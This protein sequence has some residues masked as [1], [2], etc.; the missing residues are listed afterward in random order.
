MS[1]THWPAGTFNWLAQFCS[2]ANRLALFAESQAIAD[3]ICTVAPHYQDRAL[4]DAT[5]LFNQNRYQEA[6]EKLAESLRGDPN[7]TF[8]QYVLYVCLR[9]AGNPEW[10]HYAESVASAPDHDLCSVAR[11]DLGLDTNEYSNAE[12]STVQEDSF[13]FEHALL[14]RV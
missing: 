12:A 11:T 1:F 14:V 13:R 4:L 6:A 10:M 2:A 9:E 8:K 5:R 7:N 3:L